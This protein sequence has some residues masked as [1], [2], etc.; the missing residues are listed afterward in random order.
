MRKM[1]NK[2][3]L[4]I[5]FA[6]L[7]IFFL[8]NPVKA[9]FVENEND[10]A[11]DCDKEDAYVQFAKTNTNTTFYSANSDETVYLFVDFSYDIRVTGPFPPKSAKNGH[12]NWIFFRARKP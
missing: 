12:P 6:G 5:I 2:S 10:I 8:I 1:K 11:I 9:N 4:I 3:F 7:V